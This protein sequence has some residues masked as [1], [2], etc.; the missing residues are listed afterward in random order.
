MTAALEQGRGGHALAQPARRRGRR[1]GRRGR[2]RRA[3]RARR[4]GPRRDRRRCS[5]AG[6]AGQGGDALRHARAVQ[7]RRADAAVHRR[8]PRGEGRARRHRLPRSRTRTSRAA[9]SRSCARRASRSTSA[10]REAEARRAHRALDE[11]RH[12]RDCRTSRSSSRSRST[13]AS[14]PRTG[15]SKWVTG[16]EARARVHAAARRST[17]PSPSASAPPSPTIRAS[18]SATRRAQSPL[19]VVFDTKLRLPLAR[20]PRPD[21]ARGPDAGSSAAPTRPPRPRR[22]SSSA[23]SRSCARRRSAEGRIDPQRGAAPARGPRDRHRH[24]RGR[25]RARRERARR[26]LV[27]ELHAFIAPILLGPRGRPGRR[28]LGRPGHPGRGAAHRDPRWELVRERRPRPRRR[29]VPGA[30]RPPERVERR[31]RQTGQIR[32]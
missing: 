13:G 3:P 22:R 25:R 10:C 16:P 17:T 20:A 15:A 4:R 23:G 6:R 31:P 21:R 14:R 26:A 28:G 29:S 27:D 24:G 1:E 19:R 5:D 7:P 32:H 12:D 2:R 11:V 30:L 9:A 18:P 8:H